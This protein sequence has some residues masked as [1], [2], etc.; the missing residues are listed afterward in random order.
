[1]MVITPARELLFQSVSFDE[2]FIDR[3]GVFCFLGLFH[4]ILELL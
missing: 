4:S 3:L 2:N 1:M